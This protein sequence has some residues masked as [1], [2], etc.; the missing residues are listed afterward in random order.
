MSYAVGRDAV[1]ITLHAAALENASGVGPWVD[2]TPATGTPHSGLALD[3]DVSAITGTTPAISFQLETS[4]DQ[5]IAVPLGGVL[6]PYNAAI[7][8][9][10]NI[11]GARRYVRARWTITGT[12]SPTCTFAVSGS[13]LIVYA[14]PADI[15]TLV[16]PAAALVSANDDQK[17]RAILAMSDFADDKLDAQF[18]F[19]LVMWPASFSLHVAGLS[20]FQLMRWRGYQPEPGARDVFKDLHD[21]AITYIDQIAQLGSTQFVDTTPTT[22]E[23]TSVVLT[24]VPRRWNGTWAR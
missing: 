2:T 4:K 17:A 14:D 13:S 21:Q 6:G 16:L 22:P 20:A 5:S 15:T 19:P 10:T 8:V 24:S 12:G 11:A 18:D 9:H 23:G 3:F 1:A 7:S